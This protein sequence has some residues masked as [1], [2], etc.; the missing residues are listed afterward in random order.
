MKIFKIKRKITDFVFNHSSYL[1]TRRRI[2]Y[3]DKA[4]AKLEGIS[5][6]D[7]Q[8]GLKS[9]P[10][11][12][13]IEH[14]NRVIQRISDAYN[15]AIADQPNAS[16]PYQPGSK[17]KPQIDEVMRDYVQALR[18]EDI[19]ALGILFADFFRNHGV[20]ILKKR[21]YSDL[22][23]QYPG[24]YMQKEFCSVL[25]QDVITWTEYFETDCL[26]DLQ[27]PQLGNPF[28]LRLD[29]V[30]I[31]GSSPSLN[32]YA[33]RAN[34]F[35]SEIKNPIVAEIGGGFG[36]LLYYLSRQNPSASCLDFD[37]PEVLVFAQY[38]LMMSFPEK[39]FLLYG[40]PGSKDSLSKHK[41]REYDLILLPNFCIPMLE[42]N[43]VDIF[44]N[45]HSISEM[46]SN[47]V[48]EYIHQISRA[49]EGY[50]YHENSLTPQDIG[51]G[52]NEVPVS[53]YQ[54]PD[55][56][57]KLIYKMKAIW[58]EPRYMEFLYEKRRV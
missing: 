23:N 51:Y 22:V 9:Q 37:L 2:Y 7:L 1:R 49:T 52:K 15:R 6:S 40:E 28:G 54:I 50:I 45:F 24:D 21:R 12:V 20:S 34:T 41:V 43:V 58:N 16:L 29:G 18:S 10:E 17:W 36:G 57:F 46:D 30:T 42:D 3:A 56:Q 31:T 33:Q 5:L 19:N 48:D 39:K 53:E 38:F 55:N 26:Q 14:K 27:L 4:F 35:I 11:Q 32:Y 44:L 13:N 8:A 25:M 47:T